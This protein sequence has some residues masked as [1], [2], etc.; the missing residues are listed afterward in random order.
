M[1]QKS[2][3]GK[4]QLTDVPEYTSSLGCCVRVIPKEKMA[5]PSASAYAESSIKHFRFAIIVH[6]CRLVP[7]PKVN[8][9]SAW[10]PLF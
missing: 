2:V 10:I 9:G 4:S 8:R 7:V 1:R 3:E 5:E 6:R